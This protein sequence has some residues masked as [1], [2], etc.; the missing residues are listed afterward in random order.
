MENS[1]VDAE[2]EDLEWPHLKMV[3]FET[4]CS[5]LE[6]CLQ[7]SGFLTLLQAVYK[8]LKLP[9]AVQLPV[10]DD[11]LMPEAHSQCCRDSAMTGLVW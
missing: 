8:C 11:Q 3:A 2:H 9:F 1:S 5:H 7:I 6:I 4:F 10:Q